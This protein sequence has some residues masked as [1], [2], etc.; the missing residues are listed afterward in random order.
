[1]IV[2]LEVWHLM[3]KEDGWLYLDT[4]VLQFGKKITAISGNQQN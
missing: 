3:L 4:E 2:Q 1:M